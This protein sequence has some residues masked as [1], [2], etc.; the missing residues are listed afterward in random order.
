MDGLWSIQIQ[1]PGDHP[2]GMA[3]AGGAHLV[4]VVHGRHNLP[5][6]MPGVPLTQPLPLANVVIQVT[7]AGVFHD[8]HDLAAVLKYWAE[9]S[10]DIRAS[11]SALLPTR[12]HN[13]SLTLNQK[14]L[15]FRVSADGG[16]GLRARA[17]KGL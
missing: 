17:G 16:P 2:W 14:G 5:E 1:S 8:N 9:Q 13:L 12:G 4:A 11:R 6:E 15:S 7:S 10:R 3:R